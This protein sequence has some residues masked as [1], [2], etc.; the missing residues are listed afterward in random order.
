MQP[1]IGPQHS[2]TAP[3]GVG[4]HSW[5]PHLLRCQP[6]VLY[7]A[8][9]CCIVARINKLADDAGDADGDRCCQGGD[10]AAFLQTVLAQEERQDGEG[11]CKS[12]SGWGERLFAF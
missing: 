11:A 2:S 4:L 12:G 9:V 3:A 7:R 10:T 5:Q 8:V 6:V 1:R